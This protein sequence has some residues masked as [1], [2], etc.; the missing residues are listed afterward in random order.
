M[1]RTRTYQ[2][3]CPVA[4]SLEVIGEKWSLLIVRDLL[5]GPMRFT[6]LMGTLG[7][8]TPKWLTNRL[9]DLEAAGIVE[10]DSEEGRREVYYRLTPRG[11]ELAPVIGALN[12]WGMRNVMR[13]PEPGEPVTPAALVR[14]LFGFLVNRRV[15]LPGNRRWRLVF[16]GGRAYD[17]AYTD[18]RWSQERVDDR[19][20][21]DVR[22]EATAGAFAEFLVA[23]HGARQALLA[24]MTVEGDA[25]AIAEFADTLDREM[26]PVTA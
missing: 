21:P 6:D 15:K 25:D 7:S 18:G 24:Q 22:V 12:V 3:F 13:P 2:N 5:G 10:R 14:M 20:A 23:R 26:T 8:I 1:A 11:R 19:L 9:R 17:I 16:T 4:R